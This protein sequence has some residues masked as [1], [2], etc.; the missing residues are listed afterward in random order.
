[1]LLHCE[2]TTEIV[3]PTEIFTAFGATEVFIVL[4]E[5]M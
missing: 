3:P 4:R 1:M 5:L 2:G